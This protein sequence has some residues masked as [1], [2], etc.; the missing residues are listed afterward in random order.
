MIVARFAAIAIKFHLPLAVIPL[1][2]FVET[3]GVWE[4]RVKYIKA[5]I[6]TC[7]TTTNLSIKDNNNN[8]SRNNNNKKTPQRQG[9]L[10]NRSSIF[11]MT[12]SVHYNLS[13]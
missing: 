8:S 6:N 11:D 1:N 5:Q 12:E 9:R 2:C 10:K 7:S 13:Q 3:D 4:R